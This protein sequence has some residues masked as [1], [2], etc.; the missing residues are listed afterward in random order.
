MLHVLASNDRRGAEVFAVELA[1]T[2]APLGWAPTVVAVAGSQSTATVPAEPLGNGL[3][4]GTLRRL[5]RLA[6]EH[7][8]VVAHGSTSL[9]ACAVACTGTTPFVYRSIGDPSY[10]SADGLKR[11]QTNWMLNRAHTIVSL[12]PSAKEA[13]ARRG[14]TTRIEVIPRGVRC[15]DFRPV[16]QPGRARAR[17]ALGMPLEGAVALYLGALSSEK[18]PDRAVALGR[19]RPDIEV[20][21]VG[22]GP[23]RRDIE[24][25]ALGLPNVHVGG[26]TDRPLRFLEAADVLILPSD[27]EGTPGVAIEAGLCGLPVVGTDVGGVSTV[28]K[29][30]VTGFVVPADDDQAFVRAV[31]EALIRG[32]AM[33]KAARAWCLANFDIERAAGRWAQVISDASSPRTET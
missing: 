3:S 32:T 12:F 29:H 33:G 20:V 25:R 10:W 17:R 26:A 19:R 6:G 13:L 18:R 14:V 16:D 9:P 11:R 30:D 2:L 15:Q 22:D 23:L 21:I 7:D 28:V 27:T 31:D 5:R 4:V 8:V 1:R 24:R